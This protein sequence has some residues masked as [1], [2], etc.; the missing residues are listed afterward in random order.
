[1]LYL[2][3]FESNIFILIAAL[4]VAAYIKMMLSLEQ[5][6]LIKKWKC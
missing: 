4:T 6:T 1:M 2:T 3:S 5:H